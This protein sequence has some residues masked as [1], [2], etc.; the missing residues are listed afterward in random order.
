MVNLGRLQRRARKKL[1]LCLPGSCV[2]REAMVPI[3]QS[4]SSGNCSDS[5]EGGEE[6]HD[7]VD[8]ETPTK[9]KRSYR[10]GLS[11][12]KRYTLAFKERVV[13]ALDEL[14]TAK[15][16]QESLTSHCDRQKIWRKSQPRDE[17]GLA[18]AS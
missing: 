8:L 17:V 13:D 3:T 16:D 9:E 1:A 2:M 10:C 5:K 4:E 7:V 12:R 18:T 14:K 15:N 6:H 11:K